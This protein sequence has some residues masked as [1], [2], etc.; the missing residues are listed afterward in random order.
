MGPNKPINTMEEAFELLH[1]PE[2]RNGKVCRR[3]GKPGG[4][5]PHKTCVLYQTGR[6]TL[7]RLE[8]SAH[9]QD[10]INKENTND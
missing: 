4:H 5:G 6:R 2:R 3:C 7:G 8:V 10:I 1:E 9:I